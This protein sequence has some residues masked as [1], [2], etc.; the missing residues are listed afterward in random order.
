VKALPKAVSAILDNGK[1]S[2]INKID[3][4]IE[5]LENVRDKLSVDVDDIITAIEEQVSK[6]AKQ[7]D[8]NITKLITQFKIEDASEELHSLTLLVDLRCL[9]P[10][11]ARGKRFRGEMERRGW[12]EIPYYYIR[13]SKKTQ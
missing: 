4:Y 2:S 6:V 8:A 12:G 7:K 11:K 10:F 13:D 3:K 1:W 5:Q 9:A